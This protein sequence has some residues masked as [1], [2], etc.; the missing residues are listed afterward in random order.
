MVSSFNLM[1]FKTVTL[2]YLADLVETS[3]AADGNYTADDILAGDFCNMITT[4]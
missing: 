1:I 4:S 3:F 2:S